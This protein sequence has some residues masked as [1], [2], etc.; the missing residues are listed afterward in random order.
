M[1]TNTIARDV[2]VSAGQSST[3]SISN[4][5]KIFRLLIDGLYADKIQSVTREIWSNALDSHQQ[6]GYPERPFDVSFPSVFDP[7]FRVRDF[8]VSLTHE[9]IMHMYTDLGHSTKEDT[10]DAVG[11]FGIG[12]KSPFA[13]TDNFTVT[14]VLDGEKRMYSAIIGSDGVPAIHLMGTIPTD[15]ENGI[16]VAFPVEKDDVRAFRNAAKRVSHGFDVK[17]TVSN[18]PHFEGWPELPILM[19]GED[20]RLLRGT[21]EGYRESAY[22]RMGP[23]LYPINKGALDGL[24]HIASQLLDAT[25][26]IDFPMGD[27]EITASREELVYGRNDPT[28]AS[29]KAK[30]ETIAEG[31]V[32]EATRR[33]AEAGTYFDA[34]CLYRSF[35]HDRNVP[36]VVRNIARS[37]EWRGQKLSSTIEVPSHDYRAI[38][39][40]LMDSHKLGRTQYRYDAVHRNVSISARK[41]TAVIIQDDSHGVTVHRAATRI[42]HAQQENQWEQVIWLKLSSLRLAQDGLIRLMEE[43]DGC[44]FINAADLEVPPS[45]ARDRSS[46]SRQPVLAR[47]LGRSEFNIRVDLTDED[48]D[49]GGLYVPLER[50]V[51]VGGPGVSAH[52]LRDLMVSLGALDSDTVIIGAPKTLQ[53][54]F[55]GDQ[56]VNFFE[57][58]AEWAQTLDV[59]FVP[60]QEARARALSKVRN[61]DMLDFITDYVRREDLSDGSVAEHAYDLYERSHGE[62][63]VDTR[64]LRAVANIFDLEVSEGDVTD[65][66]EDELELILEEIEDRYPLL[67][68]LHDHHVSYRDMPVDKVT[69][70]VIMCDTN[71]GANQLEAKI[72]A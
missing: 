16:E 26:I 56:W 9:Q 31:M 37:A 15:E 64:D 47:K 57:Y 69:A 52:R 25:L 4:N 42:K 29:I 63:T 39:F 19:E 7:T 28:A 32:E 27:L 5:A 68:V 34:C 46:Y 70:Y 2:T 18:D 14:A 53:K 1:K 40:C 17:P 10:N 66:Y 36:E 8:G 58:A 44:E 24:S 71:N 51:E 13:Y 60:K 11:K 59:S 41:K 50:N 61:N 48:F 3:F 21:V 45:A 65:E 43:L 49:E 30:L 72:A 62:S 54:K 55:T 6:A 23:V 12:S 35:L 38:S 20:W 22:A 33:F 67:S